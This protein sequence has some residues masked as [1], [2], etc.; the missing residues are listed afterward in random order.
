MGKSMRKKEVKLMSPTFLVVEKNAK[1]IE[2]Q[3]IV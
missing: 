2:Y 3:Q 1:K